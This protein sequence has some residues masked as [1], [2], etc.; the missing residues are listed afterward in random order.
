MMSNFSESSFVL[1]FPDD[2]WFR[3]CDCDGYKSIQQNLKEMDVC[4][5]EE[6]NNILHIFEL[7]DWTKGV[8]YH[9]NCYVCKS[10]ITS[11]NQQFAKKRVFDLVKKSIDCV[12]IIGAVLLQKS[13]GQKIMKHIPFSINKHTTIKLYSVINHNNKD[14]IDIINTE[15]KT[16]FAS[17]AKLFDIETYLVLSKD[18]AIKHFSWITSIN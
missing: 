4:W 1:N 7:K 15:Y 14:Y 5:Y 17:Y 11:K 8:D 18:K 9:E 10:P 2:N 12:C 6:S 3:I 13:Q 16:Q